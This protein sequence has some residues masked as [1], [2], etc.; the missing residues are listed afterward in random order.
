MTDE[1]QTSVPERLHRFV[2]AQL[3]P[4][5]GLELS[6]VQRMSVGL[7]RENWVFD[8]VWLDSG[9][10]V[11]ERLILRRDPEGSVLS[12]ERHVEVA[13][14]RALEHTQIPA[15]RVRWFDEQGTALGRPSVVMFREE[16]DCEYFCLTNDIR[17]L[18]VRVA[19]AHEFVDTLAAIATTDWRGL[20]LDAVLPDPGGH[21]ATTALD[22]WEGELRRVQREPLPEME[23]VLTWLRNRAPE[24]QAAVLVHGDFK[25]GN[26]LV[27]GDH[28]ALVLDWETAHVG[29]PLEDLGWITNPVRQREHQIPGVWER[30]QIVAHWSERTG[31]DVDP[32][33]LLWWNVLANFKLAVIG[34]TGVAEFIDLHMDR[35]Y[36]AP[37][38]LC[39]IMYDLMGV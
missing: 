37:L 3:P 25:P 38:S 20:G 12:T 26:A 9:M 28:L 22:H 14:L 35:P 39:R 8:A 11:E 7:S 5:C 36:N 16:G 27:R 23:V 30:A 15:P 21:G 19:L 2:A 18:D 31:Y 10:P 24:A 29:D 17:P 6:P 13:V 33:A 1:A 4:D 34:L 32:T